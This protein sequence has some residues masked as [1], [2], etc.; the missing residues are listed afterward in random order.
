MFNLPLKPYQEKFETA[1]TLEDFV[2]AVRMSEEI[3]EVFSG[4]KPMVCTPQ[5]LGFLLSNK[6][7][8]YHEF[9]IRKRSGGKRIIH[10]PNKQLAIVQRRLKVILT[11]FYNSPYNWFEGKDWE[12]IFSNLFQPTENT[13][14]F[15]H[16]RSIAT[17]ANM[18]VGK[19][20]VLNL[21]LKDF[22]PSVG[23]GKIIQSLQTEPFN[24]NY[25]SAQVIANLC[26]LEGVLPQGSPASPILSNIVSRR[27]DYNINLICGELPSAAYSRYVDDITI[28]CDYNLFD[29]DFL[30]K[31]EQLVTNEGFHIN[32][33]KTRLQ[34]DTQ[35]QEVTG[36]IVNEKLNVPRKKIKI[37][38]S[39]LHNWKTIGYDEAQSK[40]RNSQKSKS[41]LAKVVWGHL[42]FLKMV[43]GEND[44][45]YRNY[46]LEYNKLRNVQ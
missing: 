11:L 38:R 30:F 29:K 21:D 37:L 10:A 8:L 9:A 15:I 44:I 3:I 43:R 14:G 45:I 7:K 22:F 28:S 40:H 26:T 41:D 23:V 35:R 18:H 24:F 25:F 6:N 32:A 17:N 19:A 34:T 12:P 36:L 1:E 33:K 2:S 27:L 16:N 42:C 4:Q 39:M 13:H 46:L 31:L 20:Y 5:S